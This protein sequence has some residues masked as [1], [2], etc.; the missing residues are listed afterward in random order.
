MWEFLD[1]VMA[2]A[3]GTSCSAELMWNG[4]Y[5]SPKA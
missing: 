2:M 1:L 5:I 3:K 4:V